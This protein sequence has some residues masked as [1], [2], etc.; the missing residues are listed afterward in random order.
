MDVQGDDPLMRSHGAMLRMAAEDVT[1]IADV[2]TQRVAELQFRGP[3]ADRFRDQ[4]EERTARLRRVGM[5]LDD[6]A[7]LVTQGGHG[8]QA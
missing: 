7:S 4:M 5:E 1:G 6:L 3:A 8:S 2:V